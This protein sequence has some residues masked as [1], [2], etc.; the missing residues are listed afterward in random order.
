MRGSVKLV[1]KGAMY[2]VNANQFAVAF[3]MAQVRVE[4]ENERVEGEA[5]SRSARRAA[6]FAAR[7]SVVCLFSNSPLGENLLEIQVLRGGF[8]VV[9]F[10]RFLDLANLLRARHVVALRFDLLVLVHE[11][12]VPVPASQPLFASTSSTDCSRRTRSRSPA[13]GARTPDTSPCSRTDSPP[14]L[15]ARPAGGFPTSTAQNRR[16]R[17]ARPASPAGFVYIALSKA[18]RTASADTT[19]TEGREC[20][21]LPAAIS[22]EKQ[23]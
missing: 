12:R 1:T 18:H 9:L 4:R 15:A 10:L 6:R 22:S 7:L 20:R 16:T 23:R 8:L 5:G 13:R 2:P 3:F 19:E 14:P 17:S 11:K 21:T